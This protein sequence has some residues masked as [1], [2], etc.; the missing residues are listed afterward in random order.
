MK[1][2]KLSGFMVW[3]KLLLLLAGSMIILAIGLGFAIWRSM[4]QASQQIGQDGHEILSNQA[5]TFLSKLVEGQVDTVSLQLAQAQAAAIY[6]AQLVSD[7]FLMHV[8]TFDPSDEWPILLEQVSH[9]ERIYY[10]TAAGDLWMYPEMDEGQNLPADFNLSRE[11]YFPSAEQFG[12]EADTAIW[13]EVHTNPFSEKYELVVDAIAPVIVGQE[14]WGYVGVSVSLNQMI[15][16]FNQRQPIRGSYTFLMDQE[17]QLVGAPP[18]ARADL[19]P[20]DQVSARGVGDLSLT[21]NPELDA[22]LQNMVLGQTAVEQVPIKGELKYV[23]YQPLP[24]IGWRLGTA[25]PVPLAT[26]ASAHLVEEIET[27]S[28]Q[29]LTG[30]LVWTGILVF[31]A[32]VV[33]TVLTRRF[34]S[35]LLDLSAI[36]QR[37]AGGELGQRVKVGSADEIGNLATAFNAMADQVQELV[38]GLEQRVADRTR[39]LEIVATL[40][41]RLSGILKVEEL[42]ADLVNQIKENFGYYHAHIYLFDERQ[43]NLV[44]AEGTGEAGI[45]MKLRGHS[46]RLDA[47]T[48][49]V[50]RAARNKEIVRVDNVREA[51]DWL[52]N[53]LLPETYSEMAVPIISEGE[54]VGVLDVQEDE[55]GGLDESDANLLRSLSNQVAVAMRNARLFEETQS[56]FREVERLNRQLTRQAWEEFGQELTTSGYRFVGGVKTQTRPASDAWLAPMEQAATDRQLV[57]Q[58]YPGNGE[59]PRAELAVPLILRGQVIGLLGVKRE[60]VPDWSEDEMVAVETIANQIALALENARL[61]KEQEKTIVQLKEVDRLKSEFLTSMSHE[62]RTPLNSII[63]FADVLLQGIDG[64]LNEMAV[65]DIRLI[66]NSGQHLLALINDILDLSKIEAGKMELVRE[67]VNVQ[68]AIQDVLAASSSLVKNKPVEILVDVEETM[69]PI[70]ADRLRFNQ[71]L[72]NLVSNA[73]KFTDKGNITLKAR[74]PKYAP[75]KMEVSV[76]D[77]GIG[78]PPEKIKTIFDRFRQADSSTTR[79]YGG[80]GLG[81]AICK[82][83]IEMHDGEIWIESAVNVG[84][85]FAFTIPLSEVS[86][87]DQLE[88][89]G[90]NN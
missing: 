81:L 18:H 3:Q 24:R 15:A 80:T 22:V 14:L 45:E 83:L 37:I 41:E 6:G 61:S 74:V 60:E 78:I 48:S 30:V 73:A 49:L 90:V 58:L 27:S 46:I 11:P 52:P 84:S 43:E 82:Q 44:V 53:P 31:A 54:V 1:R 66:Y 8:E 50:A 25:V 39:R 57:M 76:I 77:T 20:L 72:L 26:A 86:A 55:I 5:E 33:G 65:N 34:T 35:P 59:A 36:A 2:L 4:G 75:D 63:G 51:K 79:Q 85:T 19:L 40:G 64:E 21:D 42:L 16:Q 67:P 89:V 7:H 38:G 28:D 9:G 29:A 12:S 13:S 88:T 71:I 70:Y 62:L 69:P 10:V 87:E 47:P 68:T 17:R 23:A 56:A 32:L